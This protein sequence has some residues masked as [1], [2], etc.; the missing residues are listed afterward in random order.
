MRP[1][2][3]IVILGGGMAGLS[4]AVRLADTAFSPWRVAVIEPRHEYQR[5]CTW[6]SFAL[7]DYPHPFSDVVSTRWHEWQVSQAH[8][9]VHTC[10]HPDVA[11]VMIDSGDFYA[12]ALAKLATASH[13]DVLRGVSATECTLIEDATHKQAVAI[14]TNIG[15]TCAKLVF[16]SRPKT[17]L[18]DNA[19]RQV[20]CGVEVESA[21]PIFDPMCA[22]LMDFSVM[23]ADDANAG[24]VH[25][26]YL[27]PSSTRRALV[28]DTWFIQKRDLAAAPNMEANIASYMATHFANEQYRIVYREQGA[29]PMDPMLRPS[30]VASR[31][32]VIGA[33]GGMTRAASG[34]AF[35]DTQQACAVIA[36]ALLQRVNAD[37][38]LAQPF[39]LPRWR[40]ATSYWMD[41]VFLRA[42][43]QAP[44]IAPQLFYEL[45]RG[46]PPAGLARFLSG[47]GSN[48]DVL[49]VIAACP[50]WRFIRAAIS[51]AFSS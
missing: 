36:A 7:P 8:G 29:L 33:A 37:R 18:S 23:T 48:S 6:C 13:I 9:V 32:V 28:E 50:K 51:A 24:R 40:S 46:V 42:L 14:T 5:D 49:R 30:N 31:H 11:Y 10:A 16:D 39:V 43:Q 25:F 2:Y 1:E 34:Y 15:R 26:M 47:V 22:R 45:F 19:W 35:F 20:F 3:D 12:A 4:L 44:E 41:G 38:K 21:R 27:M 17:V